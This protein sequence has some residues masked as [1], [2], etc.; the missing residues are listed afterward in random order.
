MNYWLSVQAAIH[1]P[2]VIERVLKLT[3]SQAFDLSNPNKV[4]S[5]LGTFI[6]NPYGFHDVSGKGYELIADEIIK[7]DEINP[8][9][10]ALLTEILSSGI[11]M[12]QNVNT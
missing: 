2:Q 7:L 6:N 8:T 3:H 4:Y 11:N 12:I 1:H 10:A 5:L 9:L